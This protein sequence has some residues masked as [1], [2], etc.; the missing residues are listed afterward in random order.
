MARPQARKRVHLI[1]NAHLDP[2]WR[3]QWEDG[4]TEALSTF[5]VACEFC[6]TVKGF[7]FCHNESLLYEWIEEHDPRLFE[8]IRRLVRAGRWHIAGGAYLQPDLNGPSGES[9]I[10][11][12]LIGRNYF[13]RAFGAEPTTAYNFDSFG[14]PEGLPQILAGCGFNSYIFCRPSKHTYELPYEPFRWRD[15]S[16]NEVLVRRGDGHYVTANNLYAKF[17]GWLPR[18]KDEPVSMMLWGIGNHGG[19][20]SRT[21]LSEARRFAKDYPEYSLLHSTPEAF[22]REVRR[23]SKR[24]PVRIGEMQNCYPGC[25]VSMCRIKRAHRQCENLIAATERM[26]AMAWWM[27]R[28]EYPSKDLDSAWKDLLFGEFHDILPGSGIEPVERDALA[29]FGHCS[30][31]LRRCKARLFL[32]L[33]EDEPPAQPEKT[34]IFVWNPHS[35]PVSTDLECEYHFSNLLSVPNGADIALCDARDGRRM[36]FQQEATTAP[37]PSGCRIRLA[38]PIRLGPFEKRRI[39]GSWKQLKSKP[40]AWKT[41]PLSRKYLA[42]KSGFLKIV[43]NPRTGLVDFAGPA[44]ARSSFVKEGALCPTV[45]PDYD[46]AWTCGDGATGDIAEGKTNLWGTPW[47]A[48]RSVFRLATRREA[49]EI[50]AP[51]AMRHARGGGAGIPPLRVIEHGPVRTIVEALFVTGASCIVRYYI[52]SRTQAWFEVRDR[53][54]WNEPDAMLKIE[55]PAAFRVANAI[56]ETPY[57]AIV[58]P[59]TGEHREWPNQRWVAITEGQSMERTNGKFIAVLNE[60]STGHSV[61]GNALY[62]SVLRSPAYSSFG[63]DPR[64]DTHRNRYWPRMDLGQHEVRYRLMFG[65]NFRELAVSRASQVMNIPP[66]WIVFHPGGEGRQSE[67]ATYD[68]PVVS[69]SARNV[70]VVAIKKEEGGSRL[71]VRLWEQSGRTTRARLKVQGVSG[72]AMTVVPAWG[73]KTL[74]LSRT[75]GRLVWREANLIE[76]AVAAH[77][78]SSTR[79]SR[80]GGLKRSDAR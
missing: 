21:E 74:L 44:G 9:H 55:L 66:E 35:F 75:V 63:L 51:G 18:F 57:S 52:L 4:L 23:L 39:E 60:T 59:V 19:G 20:P 10:R 76:R 6:E 5:R 13:R 3:W 8:R 80:R 25:Y 42:L 53:I 49:S 15:R 77:G 33:L 30:E 2:A 69:V 34:P 17:E 32:S 46:H 28:S 26:A 79:T 71:V 1:C 45:W 29:L 24:L 37:P 16:G 12:F 14:Q 27:G 31:T 70:L 22:F 50:G 68:A 47:G 54:L 11:Q 64:Q 7:V 40:A 72:E 38:V 36:T 62:V 43:L 78:R 61:G 48:P 58:R 67:S 56:A 73:L 65:Q 41:P